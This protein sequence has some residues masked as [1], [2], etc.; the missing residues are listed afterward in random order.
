M[1][2]W[3]FWLLGMSFV[4]GKNLTL[5]VEGVDDAIL[6]SL[7]EGHDPAK[8]YPAVFY[9]HGTGGQPTTKLIRAHT[10]EKDWIVVGM[11]YAQ[12]G[13]FQLT[14]AGM[15]EEIRVLKDVRS[16]LEQKAGLDPARIYVAGFSKG[17][18]VSGLLL[19]KERSLAGGAILGAGHRFALETV[20]KPLAKD[21]PVFVGVG[22]Y[23]GNYPFSL[24]ALVFF[25]Q[26]GAQVEMETWRGVGH[27]FPGVGSTGLKEWLALRVGKEPDLESLEEELGGIAQVE[28]P[29][30]RWW[31]LNEFGE[32]PFVVASP[33]LAAKVDGLREAMEEEP[34]IQREARILK[35][36]RRLLA[37]EIGKKTLPDLEAI[38]AGYGRIA[39]SAKGSPQGEVAAKDYERVGEILV[40]AREEFGKQERSRPEVEVKPETGRER[41]RSLRN[42]LVR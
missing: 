38:V 41:E 16:Q 36:S 4:F 14:P 29:F 37:K 1:K 42:P 34:A 26:L 9:Y 32:R 30:E 17:G 22:R 28:N 11:A 19:Q 25:R 20:P 35:E 3:F 18:W 5:E 39:E 10:G 7:P 15:D 12:R 27:S 8:S 21:S 24:K 13:T 33:D 40:Y 6:V 2:W 23:D 31:S